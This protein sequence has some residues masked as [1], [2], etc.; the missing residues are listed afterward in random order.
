MTLYTGMMTLHD[1]AVIQPNLDLELSKA[2]HYILGYT[3]LMTELMHLKLEAY[4]QDL[5]DIPAYP[6]PP[7][8]STINNDFGFEGNLLDNYGSAYNKGIELSLERRLHR[9]FHMMV[10]GSLYDSRYINKLGEV[11]HTKYNGSYS[12]NGQFGKEFQLGKLRQHR[13]LLNMRLIFIGGM[14][15]LPID[16]EQSL[17]AGYQIRIPDKGYTEKNADYFRLDFLLK[18]T[19]NREK[20]SS[21]WSLDLMN[22]T[23]NRNELYNYWDSHENAVHVEYQNPFIPVLSYRIQF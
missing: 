11:L 3:F 22:L 9:G 18:F 8:F 13:L 14:R 12:M 2:R 23:S 16:E 5:Y 21:E 1:G 6:F 15:Y 20:F 10:N 7:Y 17:E 4:Y 19:R